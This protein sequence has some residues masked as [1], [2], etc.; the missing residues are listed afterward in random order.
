[1]E[2]SKPKKPAATKRQPKT[3][4]APALA[5]VIDVQKC[6]GM[7]QHSIFNQGADDGACRRYP[8]A[9]VMTMQGI[10]NV[11]PGMQ[12]SGLCGEFKLKIA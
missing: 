9:V 1:M 6:C 7:C 5:P 4:V 8:P 3:V 12:R 10:A 2:T 11:F